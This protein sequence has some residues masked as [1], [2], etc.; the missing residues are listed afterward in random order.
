MEFIAQILQ[1]IPPFSG[2]D[3]YMSTHVEMWASHGSDYDLY[4][5]E[6]WVR[7]HSLDPGRH[8]ASHYLALDWRM[9]EVSIWGVDSLWRAE[10]ETCPGPGPCTATRAGERGGSMLVVPRPSPLLSS[11][12]GE[13]RISGEPGARTP[14]LLSSGRWSPFPWAERGGGHYQGALLV[15]P[16]P[17]S[18]WGV[19]GVSPPLTPAPLSISPLEAGSGFRCFSSPRTW[20][21]E[22]RWRVTCGFYLLT[23]SGV[24]AGNWPLRAWSRG[25]REKG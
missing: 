14:A 17:Y 21:L 7:D 11:S 20:G 1:L 4:A 2:T 3:W 9:P 22:D 19:I 8:G 23:C 24:Y 13:E 25:R 12:P 15:M 6:N 18:V 5:G 10:F 16:A